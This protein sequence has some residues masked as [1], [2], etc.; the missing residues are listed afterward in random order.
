MIIGAGPHAGAVL[1]V[2]RSRGVFEV[3]GVTEKAG[4]SHSARPFHGLPLLGD[5]AFLES[6]RAAGVTHALL[7]LGWR[8]MAARRALAVRARAAGLLFPAA[9]HP[10][11]VA[12]GGATLGPGAVVMAAAVVGPYAVVGEHAV[13]NTAATV[14]HDVRVGANTFL[15][16]GVHVGGG[17]AIGA[18]V[19]IGIG[20]VVA[21]NLKVGDGAVIGAGAV[22]LCDVAAGAFVAGVPA[23]DR[24][25]RPAAFGQA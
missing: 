21:D 13:I 8:H 5:D 11:A 9:A 14:D 15:C 6:A 1:D 16:P 17:A 10:S 23:R 19:F 2:V 25:P 4:S 20:A 12:C 24:G 22:V 3:A 7:G 18:D